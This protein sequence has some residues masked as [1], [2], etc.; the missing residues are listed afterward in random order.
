M[1]ELKFEKKYDKKKYKQLNLSKNVQ[2]H[3]EIIDK[4]FQNNDINNFESQAE[5][6]DTKEIY[7]ISFKKK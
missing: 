7:K 5:D 4:I 1:K 6:E 2:Q 3:L